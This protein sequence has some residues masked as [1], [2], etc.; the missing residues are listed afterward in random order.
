M[1]PTI[2]N[3]IDKILNE[4]LF[5]FTRLAL[6]E[7]CL[8]AFFFRH[9]LKAKENND[10][11]PLNFGKAVH[12][13]VEHYAIGDDDKTALLNGLKEINFFPLNLTE[14]ARIYS[15]TKP[16]IERGSAKKEN[17]DIE[18]HFKVNLGEGI[19]L[20]GYI[21]YL[22]QIYGAYH[23]ID[24]KTNR[25]PYGALDTYQLSLYGYAISQLKNAKYV[26]G[27]YIFL[28]YNKNNRKIHSFSQREL[29]QAKEWALKNA[30]KAL[31][32]VE[33]LQQGQSVT[34]A[35]PKTLSHKCAHCPFADLCLVSEIEGM[36][37]LL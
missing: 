4:R 35:F 37:T 36:E 22:E 28:R 18:Y 30:K 9:I 27:E 13:A 31:E 24:W 10:V 29:N 15:T 20:Q 16:F 3:S 19:Y 21:D 12:K 1:N 23:F 8:L 33:M 32:S 34:K 25:I 7:Q 2:L 11:L 6:I 14:Y 5:S 26:T 17:V